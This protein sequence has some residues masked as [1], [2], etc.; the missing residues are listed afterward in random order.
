MDFFILPVTIVVQD[1][2]GV[3][4]SN[5]GATQNMISFTSIHPFNEKKYIHTS[6]EF[7]RGCKEKKTI[8]LNWCRALDCYGIKSWFSDR[9][10]VING[11]VKII[12]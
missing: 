4:V 2:E 8:R 6:S 12:M 3:T 1:F 11:Q 9:I 7:T 10:W 5:N